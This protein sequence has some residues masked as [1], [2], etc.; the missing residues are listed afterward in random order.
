MICQLNLAAYEKKTVLEGL[1]R[2]F[3]VWLDENQYR[4]DTEGQ[5]EDAIDVCFK[6]PSKIRNFIS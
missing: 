6:F 3:R 5:Q 2:K 1:T 4:L